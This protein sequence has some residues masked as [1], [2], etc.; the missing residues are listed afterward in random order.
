MLV[1]VVSED[2]GDTE[3]LLKALG[4]IQRVLTQDHCELL[5]PK[6]AQVEAKQNILIR[7]AQYEENVR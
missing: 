3:R 5:H 7:A 6:T 2:F 1:H 4:H